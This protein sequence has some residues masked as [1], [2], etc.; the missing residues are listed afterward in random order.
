MSSKSCTSHFDELWFC[1]SP[2]YQG[3]EY[4]RRGEF[5]DCTGKWSSFY[6]CL[7][8]KTAFKEGVEAKLEARRR[9]E[10]EPMWRL[11][12][13]EEASAAWKQI[14]GPAERG[15]EERAAEQ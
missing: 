13:P 5:D 2:V 4:Y 12:T 8:L 11:R 15:D 10:P 1:Y 7:A 6:D 9:E 14:F 3:G